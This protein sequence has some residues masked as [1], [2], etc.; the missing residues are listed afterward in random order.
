M[1]AKNFWEW[2]DDFFGR[3][4]YHATDASNVGH[5]WDITLTTTAGA[6]TYVS[7]DGAEAGELAVDFDSDSEVENVC[8]SF[9][10]QLQFDIDKV[11][12]VNIRI[13]QN[14]ATIDTATQL[15]FGLTGDRNDA[16]DSIA[17][18]C[19]FRLIGSN[20]IVCESDDGTTDVDDVATGKTLTNAYKDFT[21][22]FSGGKSNVK[23]YVDGERVAEGTTFDMS[24]YTGALQPFIQI[25][26]TADT[27]VDGFTVDRFAVRGI[28]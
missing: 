9:G 19:L 27:N 3:R 24:G 20:A 12:E 17:Q 25:Q 28:R 22:D 7:V 13:K 4:V 14:Q 2:V 8:L 16:I 26:K 11:R 1:S 21:I 18:H 5:Q 23:F 10:D 6:P 15:A